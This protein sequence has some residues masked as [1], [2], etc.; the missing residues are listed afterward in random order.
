MPK[1]SRCPAGLLLSLAWMPNKHK[2]HEDLFLKLWPCLQAKQMQQPLQGELQQQLQW[3]AGVT[4]MARPRAVSA[5]GVLMVVWELASNFASLMESLEAF[6][7]STICLGKSW[8]VHAC[9]F[10]STVGRL[11][12][13]SSGFSY[14]I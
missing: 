11:H 10:S 1:L 3:D 6:N 9:S 14:D 8:K 5:A 4:E 12:G 7:I 2:P 13:G